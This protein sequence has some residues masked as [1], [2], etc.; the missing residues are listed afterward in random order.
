LIAAPRK[1]PAFFKTFITQEIAMHYHLTE[2]QLLVGGFTLLLGVIFAVAV[3]LE[4]RAGEHPPFRGFLR[5]GFDRN[6][7]AKTGFSEPEIPPA[8]RNKV[9]ADIDDCYLDGYPDLYRGQTK[10]HSTAQASGD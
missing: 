7:F 2:T 8:E 1:F 4:F 6:L 10:T 5:T 9:F 3:I